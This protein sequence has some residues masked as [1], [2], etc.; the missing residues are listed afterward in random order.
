MDN[1]DP[2][3]P[4]TRAISL[5]ITLPVSPEAVWSALTEPEEIARWFPPVATAGPGEGHTVT[6][7]WG[8]AV[9]WTSTA[10]IWEPGRH[11]R[12]VDDPAAYEAAVKSGGV[13]PLAVDWSIKGRGGTT[14]VRLVH[15]GWGVSS[16]WDEA[17]SATETGWRYFLYNLRHYLTRHHGTRRTMISARRPTTIPRASLW[18]RVFGREGFRVRG[19]ESDALEAGRRVALHLDNSTQP[20]ECR[21]GSRGPGAVGY[22]PGSQR[23][24]A[25][26]RVRTGR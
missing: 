13:L 3:R 1:S 2:G 25:L 17:F 23:W 11:V 8:P 15:S 19:A 21:T 4:A 20:L 14:V 16:E 22:T 26:R 18:E 5:E 7:S 24:T 9:E 10:V 12:W 6:F